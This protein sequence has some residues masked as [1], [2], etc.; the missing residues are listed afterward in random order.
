MKI[1]AGKIH[2]DYNILR[3]L[4]QRPEKPPKNMF[5]YRAS[6]TLR[7]L[8]W[9]FS[10]RVGRQPQDVTLSEYHRIST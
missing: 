6:S 9:T 1:S 10:P 5:Y 8:G 3:W 2:D 7:K 4:I